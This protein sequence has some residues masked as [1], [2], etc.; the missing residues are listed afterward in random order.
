MDQHHHRVR[1]NQPTLLP[2]PLRRNANMSAGG[3]SDLFIPHKDALYR[4]ESHNAPHLPSY[5][6]QI[7]IATPEDDV[8]D[9]MNNTSGSRELQYS[10]HDFEVASRLFAILDTDSVNLV[11]RQMV[12]DFVHK[13]CPVFSKRD[14]D[15]RRL[16]TLLKDS[17]SSPGQEIKASPTFDEVWKSVQECSRVSPKSG[18]DQALFLGIEGWLVFCRFIAL[19][20]YL[21]AKRRFS[22]RHLQQTMRHRNAPHGSE[23]VVVDVPPPEPPTSISPA[24]LAKYED[25]NENGLPLPELDL[26]H[27]LLAAHDLTSRRKI[28]F[29]EDR[30]I[31]TV[32]ISLFGISNIATIPLTAS[33]SSLE[34]A[35]A[36]S[37]RS[38]MG[39]IGQDESIVRRSMA[40]MKWLDDTFTSHRALG[41]TLCGRILPPFPLTTSSGGGVMS[42]HF[43]GED[44]SF[45]TTSIKKST[46][47][48]IHAAAVGVSRIRDAAKSLINPLGFYLTSTSVDSR[49]EESVISS[50]SQTQG[51]SK[52]RALK[53]RSVTLP[54]NYYNPNSPVGKAR[55]LERYLNY[56]LEHPALS[57]SFPLN[58]ILTVSIAL[59]LSC[60]TGLKSTLIV[61]FVYRQVSL[62]WKR[63]E[64]RWTIVCVCPRKNSRLT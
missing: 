14:E 18:A 57:T 62:D 15:L 1:Q 6:V 10:N 5:A 37:P 22:A 45:N 19:V 46:G 47:G 32:K 16:P 28:N 55:Q 33:W 2:W 9:I 56:L 25:R 20:Q 61:L 21:E 60:T 51:T 42:S 52:R 3:E 17:T 53:R 63:R 29:Q 50:A 30:D 44:N 24:Q 12:R 27:S 64:A 39:T 23:V 41:G 58:A 59:C 13:R 26:D 36:Y 48:A 4:V 54:E 8:F 38:S 35:V 7:R 11:S 31:G 49:S 43:Q 40:D 34:F